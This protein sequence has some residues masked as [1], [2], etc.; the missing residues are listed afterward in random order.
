MKN[1]MTFRLARALYKSLPRHPL[2]WQE[3]SL[4]PAPPERDFKQRLARAALF[5]LIFISFC[6]L[7]LVFFLS[8]IF[9]LVLLVLLGGTI[10]GLY[11]ANGISTRLAGEREM[12]RYDLFWVAPDGIFGLSWALAARYLRIS[13][14][15][16]RI[17][18]LVLWIYAAVAALV[19]LGAIMLPITGLSTAAMMNSPGVT[20]NINFEIDMELLMSRLTLAINLILMLVYVRLDYTQSVVTAVLVA[21]LTPT[22]TTKRADTNIMALGAFLGLQFGVYVVIFL[23]GFGLLGGLFAALGVNSILSSFILL[24]LAFAL[25]EG[26]LVWLWRVVENRLNTSIPELERFAG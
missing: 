13:R 24:G 14:G 25:R 19:A 10:A 11:T 9:A 5:L 23:P 18:R 21:I 20:A 26:L 8:G 1:L 15:S 22:M 3:I 17:R 2:F 16:L 7:V 12:A 4:P 6:P